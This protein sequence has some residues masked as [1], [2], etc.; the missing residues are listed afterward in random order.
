MLIRP[1]HGLPKR[2]ECCISCCPTRVSMEHIETV[3]SFL[4]R[5]RLFAMLEKTLTLLTA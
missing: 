4:N 1:L 3:R 5:R 2:D